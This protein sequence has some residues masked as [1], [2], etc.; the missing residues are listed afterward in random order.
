MDETSPYPNSSNLHAIESLTN[1][2]RN[3]TKGYIIDSKNKSY[4][5]FPSFDPLH[6]EFT[7]GQRISDIFPD[8]FS[9][10]LVDNKEKII[11]RAQELDNLV[12]SNTSPSSAI[13]VTDAS[14]KDNIATLIAH[15]HQANIHPP[16][17]NSPPCCIHHKF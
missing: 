17:Q 9:F 4:G 8:R 16:H 12:F 7:P 10:N 15:I 13:I 5:I 14:I 3:I 1:H 6:Q 2:Q 11:T